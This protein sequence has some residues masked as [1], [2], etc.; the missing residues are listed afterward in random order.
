MKI[1]ITQRVEYNAQNAEVRDCLDHR[2]ISIFDKLNMHIIPIPNKIR[3]INVWLD[4][5]K[6]DALILSGGND[7]AILP[8]AKNAFLHRDQTENDIL[9]YAQSKSIP[10]LGVCRGFQLMN[11][12]F[13][14]SLKKVTG[15]VA[16]RHNIYWR[17]N[18]N[19]EYIKR[20]VNSF[21]EWGVL[22]ND[23]SKQLIPCAFDDG[24]NIEAARHKKLNMLGIMW[25]PEREKDFNKLDLD[26]FR[27]LFSGGFF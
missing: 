7:L 25:H 13:G 17:F 21:H 20:D 8:N 3:K 10:V 12:Y 16:T 26:I 15:H 6:C 9:K 5:F 1:G 19:E 22:K 23:L 14:G 11:T 4:N 18:Q 27:M 2:W 24:G